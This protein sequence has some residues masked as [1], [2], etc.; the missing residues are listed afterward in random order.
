MGTQFNSEFQHLT[1]KSR[2][3]KPRKMS[4][5]VKTI[6][7]RGPNEAE[8]PRKEI[9]RFEIEENAIG[10]YDYFRQKIV[11]LY[12]DLTPE[13]PFRLM[14]TDEEGDNVCFSSDE[15]LRQA[16]KFIQSQENKLFKCIVKFPQP[17]GQQQQQQQQG[18]Q[19]QGQQQPAAQPQQQPQVNFAQF[20]PQFGA[21][22]QR[23]GWNAKKM[24][25]MNEKIQT[26]IMKNLAKMK[27]MPKEQEE[28]AKHMQQHWGSMG[29]VTKC[30]VD[31]NNGD[32]EMH[33]DIPIHHSDGTT[34]CST[35]TT[36]VDNDGKATTSSSSNVYPNLNE[37]EMET[38]KTSEQH[39][40]EDLTAEASEAKLNEA[41]FKMKELG[42]AGNWV[43]ELLK[44][45]DGDVAKAIEQ[46][47]PSK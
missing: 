40:Y 7:H 32:V 10:S 12:P 37:N 33:V 9:R 13:S 46:L 20:G 38:T 43:R 39:D 28:L 1:Q 26:K 25:K 2:F 5:S 41:V 8:L 18:Q 3:E 24:E 11:A 21:F 23:P 31:Q 30:T 16:V 36:T 45:V 4:L 6:L 29:N 42:F 27:N 35:T 17:Q 34:T 44:N 19:Q 47:N 22:C 14:W 15:E